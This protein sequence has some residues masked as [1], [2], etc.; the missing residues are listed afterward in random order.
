MKSDSGYNGNLYNT[1]ELNKEL[2]EE[3]LNQYSSEEF[4][5]SDFDLLA[6]L[7]ENDENLL[8]MNHNGTINNFVNSLINTNLRN[9][10]MNSDELKGFM[11]SLDEGFNYKIIPIDNENVAVFK[12]NSKP[13]TENLLVEDYKKTEQTR[14]QNTQMTLFLEDQKESANI[15][16]NRKNSIF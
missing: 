6:Y 3:T 9:S 11:I 13:D 2:F 8:I 15:T 12:I 1:I 14:L 10:L 4:E 5:S 7:A 16:D